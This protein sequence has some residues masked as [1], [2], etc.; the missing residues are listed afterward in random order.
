MHLH[1]LLLPVVLMALSACAGSGHAPETERLA[2]RQLLSSVHCAATSSQASLTV[3][4]T[5]QQLDRVLAGIARSSGHGVDDQFR[6]AFARDLIVLVS[7]GRK[8]TGG[9]S[10]GLADKALLQDGWAVLPVTWNIP[11]QGMMLTQALTSPCLLMAIPRQHYK[12]I[13]VLDQHGRV[14][15]QTPLD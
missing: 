5:D 4:T 3:I 6:S 11:A 9:Y 14:R 13:R 1:R 12:G 15:L 10:L 7:M 8:R 2:A